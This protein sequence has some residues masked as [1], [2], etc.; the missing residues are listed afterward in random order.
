MPLRQGS[1][2]SVMNELISPTLSADKNHPLRED[3]RLLGRMLGDTIREIEGDQAFELVETIRFGMYGFISKV[4][5][6]LMVAPQEPS[7]DAKINEVAAEMALKMPD[8]DGCSHQVLF[9]FRKK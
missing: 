9:V 3:I 2:R 1:P 8:F 6:P 4:V 7:F 5:H